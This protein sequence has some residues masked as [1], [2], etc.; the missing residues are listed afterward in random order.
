MLNN[1]IF[2]IF[3]EIILLSIIGWGFFVNKVF[4]K[5]ENFTF[6]G[7]FGLSGLT[8]ISLFSSIF[9]KHY[10]LHNV[11]ILFIGIL[12]IIFFSLNNFKNTKYLKHIILLSFVLFITLIT[13][14]THNDFNYYHL[15]FTKYLSE[16]NTIFGL[17]HAN[18]GY[19]LNSSLF[20]L[21]SLFILP[22]IDYYSLHYSNLYFLIFFNYFLLVKIFEKNFKDETTRFIS[23]AA[24]L[25]FNIIFYK[26]YDFG[27]DKSAQLLLVVL[28]I[29]LINIFLTKSS[30]LKL[31]NYKILIFLTIFSITI[32]SIYIS[33]LL[34]F[35]LIMYDL[36]KS[37][38]LKL[39]NL[40]IFS[41][42]FIFCLTFI[43]INSFHHFAHSGC[44][45]SPVKFT[46]FPDL[47]SWSVDHV[48]SGNLASYLEFWAKGG[49]GLFKNQNYD[50]INNYNSNFVWLSYYKNTYLFG[51]LFYAMKVGII[52]IIISSI[53]FYKVKVKKPNIK[54]LN[55]FFVLNLLVLFII[56]YI[57]FDFHPRLRYGGYVICFL[58]GAYFI[59][60]LVSSILISRKNYMNAAR[61]V[62]IIVF[63]S[64]VIYSSY[65]IYK[66]KGSF[67]NFPFY[68]VT[69]PAYVSKEYID[70]IKINYGVSDHCGITP[71]IC[72]QR[73]KNWVELIN[74]K[75]KMG[76]YILTRDY[77][78]NK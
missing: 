27:T 64:K 63:I 52:V 58:I 55:K 77:E 50:V 10:Y 35:F 14:S 41:K 43:F 25:F 56:F 33:Y 37:N 7:F 20:Y 48:T 23:L 46:C 76:F 8:F 30:S 40:L 2:F 17:G 70:N 53:I 78:I 18:H 34:I 29:F 21:N 57:W 66:I 13:P 49:V 45:L 75:K 11:I 47:A 22:L 6:V 9:F 74:I 5:S 73:D 16:N 62:C 38:N 36:I 59:S 39:L 19:N 60:N 26:I 24:F 54:S 28:F 72:A 69:K 4:F 3:F 15:P 1:F 68:N 12:F 51:K 71:S 65:Y 61:I 44:F 67:D 31:E 42:F 32:K